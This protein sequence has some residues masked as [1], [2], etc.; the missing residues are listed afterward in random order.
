MRSTDKTFFDKLNLLIEANLQ[1]DDFGID[2]ICRELGTSRSYL[3]RMIKEETDLSPS[4][5]IRKRKLLKA[6]D[7]LSTSDMKASEIAY[8]LGIDSP[9]NFSKYFAHEFGIT[10]SAF[11]KQASSGHDVVTSP[12]QEAVK[13]AP[14]VKLSSR[15]ARK[16]RGI[17]WLAGA[18]ILAAASSLLII[19][20]PAQQEQT[21]TDPLTAF[22]GKSVAIMPFKNLGGAQ[23]D[24]FCEGI[25]E[26]IHSSLSTLGNLKVI[27]STSSGRYK[28][29]QKLIP[30]IARELDVNYILEGSVLQAN[31]KI[32]INLKLVRAGDDRS[33]W[34]RSY[35]GDLQ[36]M[37]NYL[38]SVS[39]E[40]ASELDQKLSS[41]SLQKLSKIPT[42]SPAAY[43]EF[44]KGAQLINSR[45]KENLEDGIRKLSNAIAF[46][47]DFANA[48]ASLG[49]AYYLQGES[50]FIDE[51][52]SFRLS[53]QNS[54]TA[55]RLDP[56]NAIAYANLGN[57]YRAQSK[58]EQA[59]TSYQIALTHNP[60]DASINHWYSLLLRTTGN[61]KE[62]I[63]YSSRAVALDPLQHVVFGSH[64]INCVYGRELELAEKAIEDG[65][66]LFD[67]SFVYNWSCAQYFGAKGDYQKAAE[68]LKKA[69]QLN[70][71]IRVLQ[72]QRA[73]Y[74]AVSG[75][76]D[77][78][79]KYLD[80]IPDL[81][82][83]YVARSTVYA[84]LG[85]KKRCLEYFLKGAEQGI[86]QTDVKVNPFLAIIHDEPEY[87][88]TLKKFGL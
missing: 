65:R 86:I 2:E 59:R 5:Y 19:F 10:P 68:C 12:F 76:V 8:H 26:Q 48:Y 4:L 88:S 54:L 34:S 25:R 66:V 23:N 74:N 36:D 42:S 7:L 30:E 52:L 32:R 84:G 46:D 1:N 55:I 21:G 44:L 15:P 24:Y 60:N 62:A 37:L 11:R 45:K 83:Y 41:V 63:R 29:S 39:S 16:N 51:D 43:R 79:R 80:S 18:L 3:Y 31:N 67:D 64:I 61:L 75:K 81:P 38:T 27:S 17:Q 69:G 28:D 13:V 53:E 22:A 49:L 33:V 72:Y 78:A 9:Q 14:V 58:W 47:P 50:A 57:I 71:K 87:Q 85:D 20:W 73:Y 70:P 35:D 6:R 56:A 82:D 77:E 40:V